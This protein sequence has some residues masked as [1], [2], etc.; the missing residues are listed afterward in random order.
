MHID[1]T[2]SEAQ[3][4]YKVRHGSIASCIHVT[5]DDA[6]Y[7]AIYMN[8][9][10]VEAYRGSNMQRDVWHEFPIEVAALI[11]RQFKAVFALPVD[12]RGAFI[13]TLEPATLLAT[14][15]STLKKGGP[16]DAASEMKR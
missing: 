16:Y 7:T 1:M 11:V 15:A 5:T 10:K 9:A 6:E 12:Q 4:Q 14:V 8:D 2:S 13:K 3:L